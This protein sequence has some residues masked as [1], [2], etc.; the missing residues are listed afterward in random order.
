[1]ENY[2][3]NM[4]VYLKERVDGQLQYYEQ[5]AN[6]AKRTHISMQTTIIILGIL[7][8]VIVNIPTIWGDSIDVAP[9]VRIVITVL[10]LLLAL[11]TG[12]ANFRKY[13]DLW[14]TYRMTEELLKT[15]KYLFLTSSGKY[16]S[17]ANRFSQFVKSTEEIISSEHIKFRSI[18]EESGRPSKE[19]ATTPEE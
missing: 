11:L 6:N 5:A 3:L 4:E 8:P 2:E 17:A 9:Y 14:L 13:G 18:I 7:V 19:S 12:I 10:S 15:E 1:M 16:E